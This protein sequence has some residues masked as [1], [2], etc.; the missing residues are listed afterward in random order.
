MGTIDMLKDY[1]FSGIGPGTAAFNLIYPAYGLNTIAAPH[2]HNLYLQLMCDSGIL[3]LGL[4]GLL[5]LSF[6]RMNFTAFSRTRDKETRIYLIA[7]VASV[8]GFLLQGM[9]DYA[10]YNNRVTLLFWV[11]IGL[12]AILSRRPRMEEGTI[13]LRS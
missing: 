7:V 4:F 8:S 10:F 2:A 5:L 6:Y 13:W 9:T 1:W 12:G 11:I 3:G